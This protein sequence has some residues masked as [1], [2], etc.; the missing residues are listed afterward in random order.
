M[1]NYSLSLWNV[2]T[3]FNNLKMRINSAYLHSVRDH[4]FQVEENMKRA[5]QKFGVSQ[6]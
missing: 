6:I 5:K 1:F 4:K 2:V 3:I